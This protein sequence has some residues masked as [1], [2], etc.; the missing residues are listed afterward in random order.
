M[1]RN[2]SNKNNI[3]FTNTNKVMAFDVVDDPFDPA[4]NTI[5]SVLNPNQPAMLVKESDAIRTRRME[6]ERQ[7][8]EWVINGGTW[9]DV[10]RSNFTKVLASPAPTTSR[11]GTCRTTPADGTTRRTSTSS[12]SGSSAG[13]VRRP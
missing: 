6:F 7:G 3:D 2:S 5:P 4:N 1:L 10:V 13:T 9:E 8:G 11:S 12:T